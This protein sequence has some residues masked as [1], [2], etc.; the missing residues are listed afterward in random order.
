MTNKTY[1]VVKD[2]CNEKV[3]TPSTVG[4]VVTT[5]VAVPANTAVFVFDKDSQFLFTSRVVNDVFLTQ[6][7]G[8]RSRDA[9][10]GIVD[11]NFAFRIN[12]IWY[13]GNDVYSEEELGI[14][15]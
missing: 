3:G 13:E 15:Q 4:Q 14:T 7:G 8:S 6:G 12:G 11:R 1:T 9:R 5:V 10:D 2:L